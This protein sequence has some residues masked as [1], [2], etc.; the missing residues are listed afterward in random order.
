M[1]S[2]KTIPNIKNKKIF[3]IIDFCKFK[4]KYLKITKK[5]I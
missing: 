4:L 3:K 5:H 1:N 2:Q